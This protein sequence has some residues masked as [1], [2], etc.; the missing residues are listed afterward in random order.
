MQYG[1]K[2]EV[3]QR[4]KTENLLVSMPIDMIVSAATS[5]ISI[6]KIS[7][8]KPKNPVTRMT[9][10]ESRIAK[11]GATVL[12]E[13]ADGVFQVPENAV[14]SSKNVSK[15]L[16]NN[17]TEVIN[18]TESVE[19]IAQTAGN[20]AKNLKTPAIEYKAPS[21]PN[22]IEKITTNIEI[23]GSKGGMGRTS[24]NKSYI[25]NYGGGKA[26]NKVPPF[27]NRENIHRN[28][29]T[30]NYEFK[31][32]NNG[33]SGSNSGGGGS[34]KSIEPPVKDSGKTY[35][36]ESQDANWNFKSEL[37]KTAVKNSDGTYSLIK[38]NNWN[39]SKDYIQSYE[40]IVTAEPK[41]YDVT[42]NSYK[43]P[44]IYTCLS[45][46]NT[47]NIPLKN[48]SISMSYASEYGQVINTPS[49]LTQKMQ[50][51]LNNGDLS[52]KTKEK[53]IKNTFNRDPRYKIY[54]GTYGNEKHGFDVVLED[55]VD[56]TVWIIDS[57][58]IKEPK[59][60]NIGS[61]SVSNHA[62]ADTRQLSPSWIDTVVNGKLG[63]ENPTSKLILEAID[64]ERL[65]TG[66]MGINKN[67]NTG[68][69]ELILIPVKIKNKK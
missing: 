62:A 31:S 4:Q 35:T 65:Q 28:N 29:S 17:T 5:K 44:N 24:G 26:S 58:P 15:N 7:S 45:S 30:Q 37:P 41:I 54:D 68:E 43:L 64:E 21:K 48:S 51:V 56:N 22:A 9:A 33:S 59:R 18:Y 38:D 1:T 8:I 46:V 32:Q 12:E 53:I 34:K 52:G 3:N 66:I 11:Q 57:K 42:T 19:R 39:F 13:G 16:T 63:R 61:T 23:T 2:Q 27:A 50:E 20:A 36:L 55:K 10:A 69:P 47:N 14:T 40:N 49:S 25:E 6:G 67:P 60:F